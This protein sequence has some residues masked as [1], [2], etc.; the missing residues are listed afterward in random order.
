MIKNEDQQ[1]MLFNPPWFLKQVELVMQINISTLQPMWSPFL[2]ASHTRQLAWL[3]GQTPT[4][5][6]GTR[7]CVTGITNTW[8]F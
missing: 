1:Q 4:S 6:K 5:P 3:H 2:S 8:E 7:R